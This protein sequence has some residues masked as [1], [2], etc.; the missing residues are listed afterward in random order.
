LILS[1]PVAYLQ[2]CHT[3]HSK[4]KHRTEDKGHTVSCLPTNGQVRRKRTKD[5]KL[6]D[7]TSSQADT[8]AKAP[9]TAKRPMTRLCG[10]GSAAFNSTDISASDA[11][12]EVDT[13]SDSDG[14]DNTVITRPGALIPADPFLIEKS[15]DELV[16]QL[17]NELSPEFVDKCN[18]DVKHQ[19]V[20]IIRKFKVVYRGNGI[21]NTPTKDTMPEIIAGGVT[22]NGKTLIKAVGIWVAW[23]LGAGHANAPKIATIVMSTGVNGT[24]SLFFKVLRCFSTLPDH[25]RPPIVFAGSERATNIEHRTK[26]RDCVLQGGCIFVN[27]TAG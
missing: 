12:L 7:N 18:H 19:I 24:R 27:D 13:E 25:M 22:Q 10:G 23:Q 6:L 4:S 1:L 16:L 2:E 20:C 21:W 14:D 17:Y 8:P 5:H 15:E 26:M 3:Q 9:P 11:G